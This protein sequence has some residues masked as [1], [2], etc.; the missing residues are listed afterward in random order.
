MASGKHDKFSQL[1]EIDG[2]NA[3][4]SN[5]RVQA[6][7]SDDLDIFILVSDD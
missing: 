6:L 4:A 5:I 7:Q 2:F 3:S 1:I